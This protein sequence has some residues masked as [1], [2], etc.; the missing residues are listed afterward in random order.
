MAEIGLIA[1]V[2]QVAGAGLKLSQTLYQYADSVASADRRIKDI[3]KEVQLTSFVIDELGHIF[4]QDQS[5]AV[6]SRN[7]IKT[8]DETVKECS[9][10][11]LEMD[12]ALKKS[13]KR[14]MSKILWPFR[15][16]KMELLRKNIERLKS[17]L[18]LLMHV[19]THAH[20]VAS[21]KRDHEAEAAQR[22]QI[23]T[24]IRRK[25]ES[26]KRYEESLRNYSMSE[27]GS[28]VINDEDDPNNDNLSRAPTKVELSVMTS[29]IS[30]TLTPESL[31][32][33]V[34]HIQ[35]LLESLE[36]LQKVI[37]DS[38]A[39]E[40]DTSEHHQ[41][42]IGSYFRARE[43][44]DT[45]I[46]GSSKGRS[47]TRTKL[48][49]IGSDDLRKSE[50]SLT[51]TEE[52]RTVDAET[53]RIATNDKIK[54]TVSQETRTQQTVTKTIIRDRDIG[55]ERSGADEKTR[56]EDVLEKAIDIG[57]ATEPSDGFSCGKL[58]AG[59]TFD[60]DQSSFYQQ[61]STASGANPFE[62]FEPKFKGSPFIESEQAEMSKPLSGRP[63]TTK[64]TVTF[65]SAS[66]FKPGTAFG[67]PT[68]SVVEG[69]SFGPSSE[70]SGVSLFAQKPVAGGVLFGPAGKPAEVAKTLLEQ[71]SA[72][73]K[74]LSVQ[75]AKPTE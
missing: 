43:H 63:S 68:P 42:I 37:D 65:G 32:T 18:M 4:K 60:F 66:P 57:Q 50:A 61:T 31:Q 45:V 9:N 19:L 14:G 54:E 48:F 10:V 75:S 24:L 17:T 38:D 67:K 5:S 59:K 70:S 11:F 33:C 15:E 30:S 40:Q 8:A 28:T 34:Q 22:E 74:N 46:L 6:L 71:A 64:S 27:D 72:E 44:L 58:A 62:Q 20:Q 73:A 52:S 39:E 47:E 36:N 41:S 35:S 55:T 13:G 2:I 23:K 29:S 69:G 26:T 21:Q 1:S 7:A 25:K 12:A 16:P 53:E 49:P 3:A 51:R 56:L